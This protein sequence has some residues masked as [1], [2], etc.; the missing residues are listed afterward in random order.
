MAFHLSKY[1]CRRARVLDEEQV[2]LDG[3]E[4]LVADYP[5]YYDA[6]YFPEY[7]QK[8]FETPESVCAWLGEIFSAES[9]WYDIQV[10]LSL[11]DVN[12]V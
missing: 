4:H 9:G 1:P 12:R 3:E 2:P 7:H 6:L 11:E 8:V 10:I 5:D